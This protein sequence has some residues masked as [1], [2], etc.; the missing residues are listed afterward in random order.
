MIRANLGV[1]TTSTP[2]P[3]IGQ[4]S[5]YG[6]DKNYQYDDI[7]PDVSDCDPGNHPDGA[8]VLNVT[9][10]TLHPP[11]LMWR[12]SAKGD[13]DH[14]A[15]LQGSAEKWGEVGRVSVAE[16][17][18]EVRPGGGVEARGDTCS[19]MRGGM[20]LLHRSKGKQRWKPRWKMVIDGNG[21]QTRERMEENTLGVCW[22]GRQRYQKTIEVIV[23]KDTIWRH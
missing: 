23:C 3:S 15:S 12:A 2:T 7:N 22:R 13:E 21:R 19:Y 20:W 17:K 4:R 5:N 14:V 11:I 10:P 6:T 9:S 8:V 1:F 18:E 16:Q